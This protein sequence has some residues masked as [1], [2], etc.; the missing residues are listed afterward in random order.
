MRIEHSPGL[1]A[2]IGFLRVF[3]FVSLL[4]YFGAVLLI[5]HLCVPWFT[6]SPSAHVGLTH[7]AYLSGF[8][9]MAVLA[10]AFRTGCRLFAEMLGYPEF[11]RSEEGEK[12]RKAWVW[13]VVCCAFGLGAASYSVLL[14]I[15][16]WFWVE[17]GR[18]PGLQGIL[19]VTPVLSMGC[20][21]GLVWAWPRQRRVRR[22]RAR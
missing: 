7:V 13:S 12:K 18:S 1:R 20:W 17:A 21:A 2:A 6:S 19:I 10:Y 11:G 14:A 22:R 4:W 5:P 15:A 9:L 3:G 8:I 16:G